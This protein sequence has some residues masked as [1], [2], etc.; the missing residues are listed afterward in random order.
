MSMWT[1]LIRI[2]QLCEWWIKYLDLPK[3]CF[4]S[5]WTDVKGLFKV[6]WSDS[7]NHVQSQ[8]S[9]SCSWA[10]SRWKGV[11]V[12]I[13]FLL[14]VW[15]NGFKWVTFKWSTLCVQV[16]Q[17]L[18]YTKVVQ[19][20][21]TLVTFDLWIILIVNTVGIS[22]GQTKSHESDTFSD[23]VV[24]LIYRSEHSPG[25]ASLECIWIG[26][27]LPCSWWPGCASF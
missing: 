15:M 18:N 1:W 16:Q 9:W 12:L 3:L 2:A 21:T 24:L 17:I 7:R 14:T 27:V 26:P 22:S 25:E 20:F 19:H 4:L 11:N 23:A 6:V 13:G 5:N 10:S 8:C